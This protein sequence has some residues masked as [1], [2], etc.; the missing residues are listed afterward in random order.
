LRGR[1]NDNLL[2]NDLFSQRPQTVADERRRPV[3][4][5]WGASLTKTETFAKFLVFFTEKKDFKKNDTVEEKKNICPIGYKND[6]KKPN[7]Y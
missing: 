7:R 1:V 6:V 4:R 2:F 3:Q 5:A